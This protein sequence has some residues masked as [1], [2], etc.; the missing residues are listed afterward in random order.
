MRSEEW[1]K[2]GEQMPSSILGLYE[3]DEQ[4]NI[5]VPPTSD[6][7]PAR[8]GARTHMCVDKNHSHGPVTIT[9]K[10]EPRQWRYVVGPIMA[11]SNQTVE[12]R[13]P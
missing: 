5:I 10:G 6:F 4:I 2:S 13:Y 11:C 3:T 7:S 9:R 8:S 12:T 1:C